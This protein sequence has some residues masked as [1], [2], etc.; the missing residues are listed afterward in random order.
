MND[1][2]A[3]SNPPSAITVAII[4]ADASVRESFPSALLPQKDIFIHGMYGN[5]TEARERMGSSMPNLV[6]IGDSV[7]R[8]DAL[9]F[10][11]KLRARHPATM[12]V[13]RS[14]DT[15]IPSVI[16]ALAAGATGYVPGTATQEEI[17]ACIRCTAKDGSWLPRG[18]CLDLI[19]W[20]NP[21]FEIPNNGLT[22]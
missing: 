22:Q 6:V 4:E 21:D 19:K 8:K 13:F 10:T 12:V 11:R 2:R 9:R 20:F 18:L 15:K 14:G 17:V 7:P 16:D 5:L 3:P 1:S